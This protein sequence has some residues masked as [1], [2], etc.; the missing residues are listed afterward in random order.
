VWVSVDNDWGKVDC[1]TVLVYGERG[2]VF[3]V[4]SPELSTSLTAASSAAVDELGLGVAGPGR[5]A[6]LRAAPRGHLH[7]WPL[8]GR[9][10]FD[11]A[12]ASRWASRPLKLP[13]GRADLP[14]VNLCLVGVVVR[15]LAWSSACWACWL[16]WSAPLLGALRALVGLLGL[17]V[18]LLH[19]ALDLLHLALRLLRALA[20][21]LRLVLRLL[22]LALR[23][24]QLVLGLLGLALR[25]LG[26]ILG[27]PRLDLR[28]LGGAPGLLRPLP[29]VVGIVLCH[30]SL[31]FHSLQVP[32]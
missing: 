8:G 16:A 29:C 24:L 30:A 18:R 14:G 26:L 1:H 17:V 10:F 5:V 32:L 6:A 19:L 9:Y 22:G 21:L 2:N 13:G 3:G 11:G 15:L 4:C 27:L 7:G 20:G 12:G 28:L 25:L 31:V 23:L